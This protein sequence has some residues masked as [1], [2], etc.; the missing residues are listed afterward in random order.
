MAERGRTQSAREEQGD[1]HGRRTGA[2]RKENVCAFVSVLNCVHTC[3]YI[4]AIYNGTSAKVEVQGVWIYSL[5]SRP[6][7]SEDAS[8]VVA[9]R[10]HGHEQPPGGGPC[11][12]D[13]DD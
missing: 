9:V 13:E 11:E 8:A 2:G 1:G 10:H 3:T 5:P 6:S 4:T 12:A 7:E